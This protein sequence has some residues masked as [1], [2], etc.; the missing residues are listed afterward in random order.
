MMLP[1]YLTTKRTFLL[2]LL[3][4][5]KQRAT[6]QEFDGR[7][8][9]NVQVVNHSNNPEV[10][11][12]LC[13]GDCDIDEHCQ[14]GLYCF[15]RSHYEVVPGCARGEFDES[16][17]DYCA[18]KT[19]VADPALDPSANLI[20]SPMQPTNS[21]V[22]PVTA[23]PIQPEP[24]GTPSVIPSTTP[25]DTPSATPS[26]A[27]SATPSTTPSNTPSATPSASPVPPNLSA[28]P[29]E[30]PVTIPTLY[31]N[32]PQPL[33]SYH[34]NPPADKLPL[35]LCEGDCDSD[36]QCQSGLVCLQRGP[37][38]PIPG[39]TGVD[40][41]KTDYCI[42][43]QPIGE[44][45]SNDS[46]GA[47]EQEAT[48]DPNAYIPGK[49][50][51]NKV[52]LLLS[53]GLDARLVA[54]S[55]EDVEYANGGLSAVPFHGRPDAGACFADTRASNPGGWI[56]VSNAEMHQPGAGGVGAITFDA[57][58]NTIEYKAVLEHTTSNCGGGRTPW[59]TW[60]S[61]EERAGRRGHAYQVDPTGQKP[62][63]QIVLGNEGGQWESFAYDD[64][65]SIAPHFY[66]TE[67]HSRGALARYTPNNPDWSNQ[68]DILLD[69]NGEKDY[70][71]LT[72]ET[73]Q[74]G[75]FYWTTDRE[76]AMISAVTHYPLSEGI[77]RRGSELLFVCKSIRMI[78]TLQLDDFT[79]HRSS[80]VTGLFDGHPDQIQR[81]LQFPKDLLFFTEEGGRDAGVHAR[82]E[83]ARF[84]TIM[85][86]PDYQGET[87]GLAFSPD[88]RYMYVA[89]QDVGRLFCIW[90]LDGKPF[91]AEQVDIKYHETLS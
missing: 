91:G 82:D 27:P 10:P 48:N 26:V 58:G 79:W 23:S 80:T 29:T 25:S 90:R 47:N 17:T 6:S 13:E 44:E 7:E 77:D 64:R 37:Y 84:Y 8:L 5:Y 41:S 76:E 15:Q 24:S 88:G 74:S 87:T 83:N 67:D 3:T 18:P 46:E 28:T 1:P 32:N 40:A 73:A 19:I 66:I 51:T 86:S 35:G 63:E 62:S 12:G 49:L 61:C 20:S 38:D 22:Q 36:A 33:V 45:E 4:L 78:Y 50:A 85:E 54:I 68:W 55:G 72:F 43:P 65:N 39:C 71:V 57:Q 60:I 53:Q 42:L 75:T 52:G 34:G 16:R 2:V 30:G 21:P 31:P 14:E 56:Y 69:A 89:Y 11:L 70:L 81:I 59:G 9:T